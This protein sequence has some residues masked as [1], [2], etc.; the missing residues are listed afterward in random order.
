[1]LCVRWHCTMEALGQICL[2]SFSSPS[3]VNATSA[4]SASAPPLAARALVH[5]H[6]EHLTTTHREWI[7]TCLCSPSAL[8]VC[9]PLLHDAALIRAMRFGQLHNTTGAAYAF[10]QG[11]KR[12]LQAAVAKIIQCAL[13]WSCEREK[14]IAVKSTAIWCTSDRR[15]APHA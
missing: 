8:R 7:E 12:L 9:T 2:D 3:P 10:L 13:H 1:M 6:V 11:R 15:R 5:V 14:R 4:G